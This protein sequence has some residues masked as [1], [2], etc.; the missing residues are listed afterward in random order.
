MAGGVVGHHHISPQKSP[1]TNI[2]P[3]LHFIALHQTYIPEET[4]NNNPIVIRQCDTAHEHTCFAQDTL[5]ASWRSAERYDERPENHPPRPNNDFYRSSSAMRAVRGTLLAAVALLPACSASIIPNLGGPLDDLQDLQKRCNNPCGSGGWLC[6]PDD[7][8][9]Y[10]DGNDKAQ[11]APGGGDVSYITTT[12][13]LTNEQ[14]FTTTIAISPATTSSMTCKWSIGETSC[15][16]SCCSSTEYCAPNGQCENSGSGSSGLYSSL[17]TVTTILTNT[18][19]QPLRPTSNTLVTVTATGTAGELITTTQGFISPTGTIIA[20][21]TTGGG[22]LSAGAIAGIVIGVLAAIII[23]ILICLC[24]CA[25]GILDSILA[26]FGLRD[27]KTRRTEEVEV[28]ESRHSRRGRSASAA[29]RRTWFGTKPKRS[30]VVEEKRKSSGFGRGAGVAAGLAGLAVA[31]GLKRRSDRKRDA[32]SQV[33][34]GSSYYSDY[35]SSELIPG[36]D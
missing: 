35:T 17:V 23:L 6:C 22:G 14:T 25:K 31:L 15:G 8:T 33:S 3:I 30:S 11:C 21:S 13:V 26:L 16:N 29:G 24:C 4:Q 9:C 32:K 28:Y 18:A 27:R 36:F 19:D 34:Y 7:T 20:E 12:Y 2:V 1:T 5:T 10:I